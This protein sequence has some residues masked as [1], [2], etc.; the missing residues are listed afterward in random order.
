MA[1]NR[2]KKKVPI[3]IEMARKEKDPRLKKQ[4]IMVLGQS[5]DEEAIKFLKEI[6]EK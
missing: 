2:S 6:I 3:L 5:K 4:I 1:Q